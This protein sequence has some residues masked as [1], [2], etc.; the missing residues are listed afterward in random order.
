MRCIGL[1]GGIASGKSTVSAMFRALGAEVIDADLLARQVVEPGQPA[2]SEIAARF[3]GVVDGQGRLDRAKLGQQVFSD[4]QARA[5][6]NAITHPRIH[7]AFQAKRRELEARGVKVALYDAPLIIEKGLQSELDGVILVSVPPSVQRQRLMERN[8]LPESE[9]QARIDAQLPL[10][11]KAR[12]CHWQIDNSGTL[13]ATKAQVE[14]LWQTLTSATVPRLPPGKTGTSLVTGFP[15]FIGKRLVELILRREPGARLYLLVQEK[16]LKEAQQEV[17]RLAQKLAG[18][19]G[20]D[21]GNIVLLTGDIVDM[22]LG[23]SGEEYQALCDSVTHIYHLAAIS[24]LGAAKETA[25]RVN[26]DGTRN[27]IDLARDCTKLE[28]LSYFS[29]CY[30]AGDRVGVIAEDELDCGQTFRNAYEET[31]FQA[32]LLMQR[33]S[34]TLPITIFRPSS[35]V[36]DS[37]TGEI[38]RF[39]GPYYVG[40]LLAMSPLVMPLPLPGNG[41]APL[42]VVPV[43]FVVEATWAIAHDPRGAGRTVHL[44]DPNPMSARRVYELIAERANRR[45]PKFTL[46]AKATD[47]MLRLPL[48]EKL[49]RPQRAAIHY[50]NHLALYNCHNALELLDGTGIRCPPLAT[51]LDKLVDYVRDFYR[52]RREEAAEVDDP[53]DLPM[54]HGTD[55]AGD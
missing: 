2:L 11:H 37:R 12:F 18:T 43:D 6:L 1:T 39:D 42:N 14:R 55:G 5:A 8:G 15:G 41:V 22:D 26:V 4:D 29:T 25:R 54:V 35:V 45:L 24:Y 52:R 47:F 38:D 3:P 51:Y 48:L 49:A 32:E 46:P 27:V 21:A 20:A 44:V 28:R 13:E 7:E 33:A 17:Q 19:P 36:G 10:E 9:A 50:V 53:L 40:I 30:V 31:K 16:F 23:L 34:E